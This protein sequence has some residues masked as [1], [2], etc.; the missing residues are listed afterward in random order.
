MYTA[1]ET[2]EMIIETICIT[3]D[4]N[5]NLK[6]GLKDIRI[7]LPKNKVPYKTAGNK[8]GLFLY[9]SLFPQKAFV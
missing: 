3:A 5:D 1:N 2:E 9:E 7:N 4:A 6:F 8:I